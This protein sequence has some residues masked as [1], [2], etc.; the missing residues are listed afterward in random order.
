MP[1]SEKV[2]TLVRHFE[3][4]ARLIKILGRELLPTDYIAII[5]L[6]KN[7]YDSGAP[8]VSVRLRNDSNGRLSE[9]EILDTGEGMSLEE[10]ERIWLVP[11]YSEKDATKRRGKRIPLGEK[12]IGRFAADK[13]GQQLEL[14]TAKQSEKSAIRTTFNWKEYEDKK[15]K[16]GDIDVVLE[17]V[18]KESLS[19]PKGT[20]LI[21]RQL[22]SRWDARRFKTL[23]RKLQQLI[24]PARPASSFSIDYKVDG[25]SDVSRKIQ[26]TGEL[27]GDY[28]LH[29]T[30]TADGVL[31]RRLL[32][33]DRIAKEAK[34][35][36]KE[37]IDD[38]R[39]YVGR[40][41]FG[42]TEGVIYYQLFDIKRSEEHVF[43]AGVR[44]YRDSFRVEPYG[45]L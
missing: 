16:F 24:L 20:R 36:R 42:P 43:D 38:I 45:G 33:S 23:G 26:A 18:P 35:S 40:S 27:S 34:L 2:R 9:I 11:G 31:K 37:P 39:E 12:G 8:S 7:A 30:L 14:H 1:S 22:N 3:P 25:H 41:P 13:L 5:E 32:R 44:L 28:I 4:A 29:F 10:F 19:L 6:I 15:K 17:M 21:I